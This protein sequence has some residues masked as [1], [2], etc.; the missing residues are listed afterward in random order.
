M[1]VNREMANGKSTD[2]FYGSSIVYVFLN[3]ALGHHHW[4]L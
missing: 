4:L 3:E 2:I 1:L